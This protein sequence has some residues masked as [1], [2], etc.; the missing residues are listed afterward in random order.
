MDTCIKS[1]HFEVPSVSLVLVENGSA[2]PLQQRLWAWDPPSPL[3][4]VSMYYRH[5]Y[6]KETSSISP[7]LSNMVATS[8]GGF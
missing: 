7:A 2:V 8:Q 1:P 3:G 6:P 5:G 4:V